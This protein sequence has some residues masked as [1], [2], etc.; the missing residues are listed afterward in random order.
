[1]PKKDANFSCS[2]AVS[3]AIWGSESRIYRGS[4]A[5]SE[6]SKIKNFH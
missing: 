6:V 1:M 3:Q 5:I 4:E 2:R